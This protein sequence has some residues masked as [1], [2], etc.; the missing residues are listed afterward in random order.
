MSQWECTFDHLI[1]GDRLEM[2]TR[3]VNWDIGA[4]DISMNDWCC[5]EVVEPSLSGTEKSI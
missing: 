2:S 1:E 4:F 5:V 3:F